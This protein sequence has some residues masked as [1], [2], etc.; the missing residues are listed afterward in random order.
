MLAPL[1]P[2]VRVFDNNRDFTM[3]VRIPSRQAVSWPAILL[4]CVSGS[5][6]I[7]SAPTDEAHASGEM[8]SVKDTTVAQLPLTAGPAQP[9]SDSA[10]EIKKWMKIKED[11]AMRQLRRQ[12]IREN[13]T[14]PFFVAGVPPV[15]NLSIHQLAVL[16]ATASGAA[17]FEPAAATP[18]GA[19]AADDADT[20]RSTAL[21]IL[22]VARRAT[23]ERPD[24]PDS[25]FTLALALRDKDLPLT[26]SECM[27][28]AVCAYRQCLDRLPR[29]ERYKKGQF[30]VRPT[31]VTLQLAFAYL[32][33]RPRRDA[34]TGHESQV[35]SG[36]PID[37]PPLAELLGQAVLEDAHG[38]QLRIMSADLGRTKVPSTYRRVS[39]DAPTFLPL[40]AARDLLK[41][42][43][44]YAPIDLEGH[45]ADRIQEHV[46]A[47]EAILKQVEAEVTQAKERSDKLKGLVLPVRVDLARRTGLIVEAVRLLT[48]KEVDL[49]AEYKE[50]LPQAMILHVAMELVL[51]RIERAN[52]LLKTL[53]TAEWDA[54]FKRAGL[55]GAL[56]KLKYVKAVAAG[57]YKAA[58]DLWEALAGTGIGA[59]DNM[60]PPGPTVPEPYV[61]RTLGVVLGKSTLPEAQK[62][63][64]E[65]LHPPLISSPFTQPLALY[66]LRILAGL[67]DELRRQIVI[68]LQNESDFFYRRGA[69]SLLEGD[70]PSA[71]RCFQQTTRKSPKGWHLPDFV[72][73]AAVGYLR[74][75]DRVEQKTVP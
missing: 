42:T 63:L 59:L 47:I 52:A 49:L 71:R 3:T 12:L 19:A 31:A 35:F 55:T 40:D 4:V 73:T 6:K 29:P 20:M 11:A 69:L 44:A 75:L 5:T 2:V 67:T 14:A 56:Q 46:Q 48:D 1:R 65:L 8:I 41:L 23:T 39:G 38:R 13:L 24:H 36:M 30:E 37:M 57:E 66:H 16:V 18:A 54:Q 27:L 60:P 43:L 51:G 64:S 70:I 15:T 22:R 58:G 7:P 25:Y 28:G 53:G 9:G 68:Q 21:E 17:R 32:N 45:P 10:A 74:M 33:P 50:G 72:H 34:K 26:E 61:T 62:A